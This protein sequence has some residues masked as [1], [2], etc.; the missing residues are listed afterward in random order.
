MHFPRVISQNCSK[1]NL[2]LLINLS[3]PP[4][5]LLCVSHVKA[6]VMSMSKERESKELRGA[7]PKALISL[8]QFASLSHS[9][10]LFINVYIKYEQ[11]KS[12]QQNPLVTLART[13]MH[14]ISMILHYDVPTF[15]RFLLLLLLFL[16]SPRTKGKRGTEDFFWS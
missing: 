7:K 13:I 9:L 3:P 12:F 11:H 6:I 14:L 16:A 4:S 1:G 8:L 2:L 10:A 15:Y 5:P